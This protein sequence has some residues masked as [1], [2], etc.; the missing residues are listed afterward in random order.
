M[1]HRH[2]PLLVCT[3]FVI[4][5]FTVKCRYCAPLALSSLL[6]CVVALTTAVPGSS[7]HRHAY[8]FAFFE[9]N[10]VASVVVGTCSPGQVDPTG[11][12]KEYLQSLSWD[13]KSFVNLPL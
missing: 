7:M 1:L 10:L 4:E 3:T 6:L 2:P 13:G 5:F 12:W 11:K 8:L 9:H